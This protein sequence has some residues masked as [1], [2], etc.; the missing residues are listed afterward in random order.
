MRA[1]PL[2]SKGLLKSDLGRADVGRE[3]VLR[4]HYVLN[5]Y[6]NDP[7]CREIETH[8]GNV[9]TLS[10]SRTSGPFWQILFGPAQTC[11]RP[12]PRCREAQNLHVR[13]RRSHVIFLS[14]H[15]IH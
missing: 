3:D 6:L 1:D 10:E 8:S 4:V 15:C 5:C 7:L 14:L 11:K 12:T 13:V 9:P 2:L